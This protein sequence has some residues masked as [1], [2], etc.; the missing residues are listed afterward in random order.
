MAVLVFST[1]GGFMQIDKT[2]FLREPQIMAECL[3]LRPVPLITAKCSNGNCDRLWFFFSDS[4]S[5]L[6]ATLVFVGVLGA[7][8]SC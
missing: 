5:L 2:M 6:N 1:G 3:V 7:L 8:I 4:Y